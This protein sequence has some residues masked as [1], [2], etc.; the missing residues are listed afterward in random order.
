M[1]NTFI[2]TLKD[3]QKSVPS[4][5]A[6]ENPGYYLVKKNLRRSGNGSGC[7]EETDDNDI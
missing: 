1:Y 3:W 7:S 4:K 5:K 2:N 6:H